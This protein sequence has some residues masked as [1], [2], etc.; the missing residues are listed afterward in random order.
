MHAAPN[1]DSEAPQPHS[2]YY[3]LAAPSAVLDL[4]FKSL[5]LDNLASNSTSS[6]LITI[7]DTVQRQIL[8]LQVPRS[9]QLVREALFASAAICLSS[10]FPARE[11][12]QSPR[13]SLCSAGGSLGAGAGGSKNRS[14]VT[15]GQ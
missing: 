2:P 7:N 4:P 3:E 5:G 8:K 12:R 6:S 14:M 11:S 15:R 9:M 10:A 13:F 1:L